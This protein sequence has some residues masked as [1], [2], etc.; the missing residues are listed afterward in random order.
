TWGMWGIGNYT[1][2][3][4]WEGD[5]LVLFNGMVTGAPQDQRNN[6]SN[7]DSIGTSSYRVYRNGAEVP[8]LAVGAGIHVYELPAE[9]GDYR[10]ELTVPKGE[11]RAYPRTET[12]WT[13]QAGAPTEEA[14]TP[15]G[16]VCIVRLRLGW[17]D[18]PCAP[19][20]AVFVSY[21][22]DES[23]ALDNTVRAPGA[24]WFDV[25]AYHHP[26]PLPSPAIA[27]L[28]LWASYD[29]GER[30]VPAQVRNEGDGKF[31]VK[32]VHPPARAEAWQQ[33]SLRVEAWDVEGNRIEQITYDAF[34][35]RDVSS[36]PTGGFVAS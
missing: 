24:H 12:T 29:G 23:L 3:M 15:Y 4:C 22:L 30:W 35:L 10:V 26:S 5:Y 9:P 7:P 11:D 33:V 31:R 1:C 20:P 13:F 36:R 8:P 14:A 6:G 34:R 18:G 21:D 25:Y 28:K 32:L 2:L 16:Y 27:G 17:H 19:T